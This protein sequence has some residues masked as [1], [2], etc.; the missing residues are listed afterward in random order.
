MTKL[1]ALLSLFFWFAMVATVALADQRQTPQSRGEMTISFAPLVKRTAPAV[2]NVYA[3]T[4]VQQQQDQG[5]FS[6]PLFRHFF[7]LGAVF[8]LIP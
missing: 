7:G 4:I 8:R 2:V 5:P 6:D 1:K 3:K